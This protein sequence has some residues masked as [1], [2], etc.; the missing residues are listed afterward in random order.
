MPSC[1]MCTRSAVYGTNGKAKRCILH[2]NQNNVH[3]GQMSG[4]FPYFNYT[5]GFLLLGIIIYILYSFNKSAPMTVPDNWCETQQLRNGRYLDTYRGS[6]IVVDKYEVTDDEFRQLSDISCEEYEGKQAY[7]FSSIYQNENVTAYYVPFDVMCDLYGICSASLMF[8]CP[9]DSGQS[10]EDTAA[11]CKVFVTSTRLFNAYKDRTR[12]IICKNK[13]YN[14]YKKGIC[15]A[16]LDSYVRY[17]DTPNKTL[18]KLFRAYPVCT[19]IHHKHIDT[20][21]G[22]W[23]I[24]RTNNEFTEADL[25]NEVAMGYF[26]DYISILTHNCSAEITKF[27]TECVS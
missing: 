4:G 25:S 17:V 10:L 3:L 5:F 7:R 15:G 1:E 8:V 23:Y 19:L 16:A 6:E 27:M 2:K 22:T 12:N 11:S 24:A 9:R 14:T 13:F 26:L 21:T 18:I 20:Y